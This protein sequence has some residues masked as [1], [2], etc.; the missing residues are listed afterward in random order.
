MHLPHNIYQEGP[1]SYQRKYTSDRQWR[2]Y[3]GLRTMLLLLWKIPP[4][5]LY[6]RQQRTITF[7]W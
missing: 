5:N 1:L 6:I 2:T 3:L 7:I 4:L